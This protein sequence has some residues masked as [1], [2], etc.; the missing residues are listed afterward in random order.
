MGISLAPVSLA[1]LIGVPISA[2]TLGSDMAWWKGITLA[3]V[4]L[5][6]SCVSAHLFTNASGYNAILRHIPSRYNHMV[7]QEISN[8]R[9]LMYSCCQDII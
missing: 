5:S 1:V 9:H 4:S 7:S 2:A 6:L 3:S 8:R